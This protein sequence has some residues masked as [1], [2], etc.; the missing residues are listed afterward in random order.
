MWLRA[1]CRCL[2]FADL[3]AALRQPLCCATSALR[4]LTLPSSAPRLRSEA[5]KATIREA[6]ELAPLH[7]PPNLYCIEAA[8]QLFPDAPHVRQRLGA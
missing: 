1:C 6:A 3:M 4:S 5:A 8:Q 2:L 7:N